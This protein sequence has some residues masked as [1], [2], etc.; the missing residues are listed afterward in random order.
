MRS[1]AL[2]LFLPLFLVAA[3]QAPVAITKDDP[4]VRRLMALSAETRSVQAT[5][6]QE[7]HMRVL[8]RPVISEGVFAYE[9]PG[10][11]RWQVD[12]PERLVALV[13]KKV[14][15]IQQNGR[16]QDVSAMDRQVYGAIT[17]LVE[18]IVSGTVLANDR[19]TAAYFKVPE[20][21]LVVVTPD[22]R[23]AKRI[24]EVRL[25]FDAKSLMLL[26]LRMDQ[27]NGD[28]MVTRF[29]DA[30]TGVTFSATTFTQF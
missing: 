9:R 3:A 17:D 30:H 4:L 28:H 2:L 12:T 25:V 16:E 20:G 13:E 22:A 10:R 27:P 29:H 8:T 19:M 14:V 15:R 21:L 18:G 24:K 6:T 5:F 26:E 11:M 7:K 23:M 1:I